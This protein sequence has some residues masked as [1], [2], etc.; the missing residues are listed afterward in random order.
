MLKV[1]EYLNKKTLEDLKNEYSIDYIIFDDKVVLSYSQL[2]SPKSDPIVKECRGLI[3]DKNNFSVMCYPFERFF[4][5]GEGDSQNFNLSNFIPLEKLDGTLLNIYN[6]YHQDKWNTA[7]RRSA[8]ADG[9]L[10]GGNFT[11]NQVV[12]QEVFNNKFQE[13][14]KQFDKDINLMTELTSPYNKVIKPYSDSKITL[15][16]AR[17]RKTLKEYN[18]DDLEEIAKELGIPLVKTYPIDNIDDIK[19]SFGN[20][21]GSERVVSLKTFDEGFVLLNPKTMERVKIKNPSYTAIAHLSEYDHE[22]QVR[23]L[24]PKRIAV[25]VMQQD[26]EEYLLS[27][28]EDKEQFAPY[29]DAYDKMIEERNYVL[30]KAKEIENDKDFALE[31][32]SSPLKGLAF[33]IRNGKTTF[34]EYITKLNDDGKYKM[35]KNFVDPNFDYNNYINSENNNSMKI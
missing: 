33:S 25:L 27:F 1:Q 20:F 22:N 17:N 19:K 5:F 2:D 12:E 32:K 3:L 35:L 26:H 28:P 7:T 15:I 13:V 21:N 11:I 31:I 10:P 29:I 6:D 18:M 4:N 24:M 14:F 23:K 34:S 30:L 8:Y 16:G 9:L